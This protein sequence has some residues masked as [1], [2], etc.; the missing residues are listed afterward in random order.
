MRS[1]GYGIVNANWPNF[2][3]MLF[4]NLKR[5]RAIKRIEFRCRMAWLMRCSSSVEGSLEAVIHKIVRM[6]PVVLALASNECYFP[7]TILRD[8]ERIKRLGPGKREVDVKVLDGGLSQVIP[9]HSFQADW[10]N[11]QTRAPGFCDRQIHRFLIRRHSD[12]AN[13]I[14]LIAGYCS[15]TCWMF[16]V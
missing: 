14:W 4:V 9:G 8:C 2:N 15:R 13:R 1:E 3:D 11:G 10:A 5:M 16:H 6:E 12:R 7:G